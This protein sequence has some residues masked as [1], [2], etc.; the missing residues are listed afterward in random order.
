M[1]L[2]AI[3]DLPEEA[4]GVPNPKLPKAKRVS[5]AKRAKAFRRAAIAASPLVAAAAV[6]AAVIVSSGGGGHK[7]ASLALTGQL[8]SGKRPQAAVAAKAPAKADARHSLPRGAEVA[9]AEGPTPADLT[10]HKAAARRRARARARHRHHATTAPRVIPV[11]D[12]FATSA[13]QPDAYQPPPKPKH[14]HHPNHKP[15]DTTPETPTTTQP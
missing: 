13:P 6:L 12:N 14:K 9:S 4:W 10:A 15:T 5:A 1:L 8:T 7:S 2:V 3:P 11:S